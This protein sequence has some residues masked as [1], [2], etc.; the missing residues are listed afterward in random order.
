MRIARTLTACLVFVGLGFGAAA[1]TVGEQTASALPLE[2]M[3]AAVTAKQADSKEPESEGGGQEDAVNLAT[4]IGNANTGDHLTME[5]VAPQEAILSLDVGG[6]TIIPFLDDMM[7]VPGER[8]VEVTLQVVEDGGG[9][10]DSMI[11]AGLVHGYQGTDQPFG[12]YIL[13][14]QDGGVVMS[15]NGAGNSFS[16]GQ[17]LG[18]NDT[19]TGADVTF[20][21]T[22]NGDGSITLQ[23]GSN[24]L[25]LDDQ[26]TRNGTEGIGTMGVIV[27]GP[28]VYR[29]TDIGFR[30]R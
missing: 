28:G 9:W 1:E 4:A 2:L 21:F 8:V 7:A 25:T 19:A 11:G 16:V 3:T 26:T 20:T 12:A 18:S 27:F 15:A 13:S 29:L 24:R 5:I 30:S 23:A 22:E 6:Y 17:T 14:P 10:P